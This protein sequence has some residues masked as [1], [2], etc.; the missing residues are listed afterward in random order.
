MPVKHTI[1]A[2]DGGTV[3]VTISRS[4][5]IKAMCTECMGFGEGHPKECGAPLCPL[6]PFRGKIQLAYHSDEGT[7]DE[8]DTVPPDDDDE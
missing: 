2:K 7:V 1:R 5:A 3:E 8:E 6:F 4:Q